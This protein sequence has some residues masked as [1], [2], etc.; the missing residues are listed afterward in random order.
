MYNG[1]E[2]IFIVL[3]FIGM[4]QLNYISVRIVMTFIYIC[5]LLYILLIV[6]EKSDMVYYLL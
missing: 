3:I 1:K 5:F 4:L 6:W 2:Y